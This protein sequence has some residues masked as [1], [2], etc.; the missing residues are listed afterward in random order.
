MGS[1][2]V[3]LASGAA[4]AAGA[5]LLLVGRIEGSILVA[6]ALAVV[7][8]TAALT[9]SPAEPAAVRSRARQGAVVPVWIGIVVVAAV[10]AGSP[11]L[12][13]VRGANAVAGLAIA[14]GDVLMVVAVWCAVAAGVLAIAS[15]MP[16]ARIAAATF[17]WS[18][19]ELVAL[20]LQAL[21]LASLFA[22]PTVRS[23][24]D[25]VW[26]VASTVVVLIAVGVAG[27]LARWDVATPIA[28][29]IALAGVVLALAGGRP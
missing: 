17:P 23:A 10:R 8:R 19:L 12:A 2:L 5:A 16:R 26:W 4:A 13:D 6:V 21:A 1:P 11:T 18:R 7:A 22:A 9:A 29:V 20:G 24:G 14:R 28:T 15:P 27:R 3:S 25:V